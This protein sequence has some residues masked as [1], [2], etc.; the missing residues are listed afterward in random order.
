M[1]TDMSEKTI[2]DSNL[3]H[4]HEI[5][6]ER[7]MMRQVIRNSVKRKAQ[8]ELCERPLK[9]IHLELNN[10]KTDFLT[11]TDISCIRKGIYTARRSILPKKPTNIQDVHSLLNSLEIKTFD[12]EIFL[13]VNDSKKKLGYVFM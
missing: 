8:E 13:L 2:I 12:D 10:K 11:T 3:N 7:K 6:S 4:S 5:E 9:L 1:K